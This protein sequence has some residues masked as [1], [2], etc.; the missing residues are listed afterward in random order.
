MKKRSRK[1]IVRELDKVFSVYIRQRDKHC[2]VCGSTENLQCGHLF[3]RVS[4]STRWDEM[5]AHAQCRN[6]NMVHEHNPHLYTV[7]FIHKYG[8]QEYEKLLE[9]HL[10]PVKL[11][12][13]DIEELINLYKTK[14]KKG[15]I[16]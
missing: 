1:A 10:Q 13:R 2:I 9:K 15:D 7:A 11:K 6:C 16:V 8:Q 5:N 3:S 4:Y 12:D 14:L